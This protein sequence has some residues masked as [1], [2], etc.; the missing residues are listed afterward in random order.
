[1]N[2]NAWIY[3]SIGKAGTFV[4][5]IKEEGAVI[6]GHFIRKVVCK[7]AKI[8]IMEDKIRGFAYPAS[9]NRFEL[10]YF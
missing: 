5:A 10:E 4:Q 3:I 2:R 8:K 1:M 9:R 6:T 7:K